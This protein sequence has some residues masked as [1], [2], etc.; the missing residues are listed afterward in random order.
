MIREINLHIDFSKELNEQE[1]IIFWDEIIDEIE[2]MGLKAG[3]RCDVNFYDWLIDYSDSPFT[4][5]E[6]IDR[7]G[8]F[9]LEK[10]DLVSSF[11]IQ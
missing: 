1:Q 8:D 4:K 9:L 11:K 3:G 5:G 7:I 10:D 2:A 6:I